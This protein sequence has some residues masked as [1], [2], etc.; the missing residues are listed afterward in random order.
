MPS[1][2]RGSL[3]IGLSGYFDVI[4]LVFGFVSVTLV[5]ALS[6]KHLT[7]GGSVVRDHPIG[8]RRGHNHSSLARVIRYAPACQRPASV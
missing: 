5:S 3:W 6:H 1:S 2:W 7:G 8:R 4:H